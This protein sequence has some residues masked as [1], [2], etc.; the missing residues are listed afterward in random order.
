MHFDVARSFTP[1]EEVLRYVDNLSRHK[2]N[3]LHLH[4]V[5]DEG[6]RVEI[7]SHPELTEV[8]AW[9]GGDSPLHSIY[10]RWG[11]RYGGYYTQEQLRQ[12]VDYAAVRNITV[13]PEIDLPGHSLAIAKAHPEILCPIERNM[14]ATAGYDTSNVWCVA[15]E[16]NYELLEDIERQWMDLHEQKNSFVYYVCF[17][18]LY[19]FTHNVSIIMK[20]IN[21]VG[22]NGGQRRAGGE[23][24][25]EGDSDEEIY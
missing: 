2:I 22:K 12:L 10:G 3:T 13:V 1:F 6:W 11:E 7:K 8:G 4:L 24:D 23:G 5:D 21:V 18:E 16:E 19:R 17:R 15:R 25:A 9:R 20:N 14:A